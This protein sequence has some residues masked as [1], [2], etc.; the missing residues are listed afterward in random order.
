MEIKNAIPVSLLSTYLKNII[1][2]EDL[3]Q[4]VRIYGEITDFH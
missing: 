4:N 2:S 1:E 3:L